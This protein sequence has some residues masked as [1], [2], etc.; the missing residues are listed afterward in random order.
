[1]TQVITAEE[2]RERLEELLDRVERGE[3]FEIERGGRVVAKLAHD[4]EELPRHLRGTPVL[5]ALRGRAVL[6]EGWDAPLSDEE[7][8]DWEEGPIFPP[9]SGE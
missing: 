3:E 1:V 9:G 8:R 7:L 5:G 6:H 2:A 4:G